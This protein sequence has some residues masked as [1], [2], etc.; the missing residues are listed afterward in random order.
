[1]GTAVV[2]TIMVEPK[3]SSDLFHQEK[4]TQD[5]EKCKGQCSLQNFLCKLSRTLP[6]KYE[7]GLV[8]MAVR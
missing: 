2:N 6:L 7:V 8:S 4:W 3:R 1:M 5:Q